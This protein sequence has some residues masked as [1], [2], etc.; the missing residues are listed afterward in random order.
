VV[1]VDYEDG[2]PVAGGSGI[3]TVRSSDDGGETFDDAV[4]MSAERPVGE[5]PML[6]IEA[7]TSAGDNNTNN[8]N[9][10]ADDSNVYISWT[11]D[12]FEDFGGNL[13]FA[14][15]DNSGQSFEVTDLVNYT[16]FYEM[17]IAA[18]ASDDDADKIYVAGSAASERSH[19]DADQIFFQRSTDG[20]KTFDDPI[21]L[22]DTE[23]DEGRRFPSV[24]FGSLEVDDDEIRVAWIVWTGESTFE[25]FFS[26][27]TDGGA[28]FSQPQPE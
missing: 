12:A 24:G 17:E 25:R 21:F 4:L 26:V 27:S 22:D 19:E 11:V 18:A 9:N 10:D 5:I 15:S 16:T 20:G 7:T 8:N 23:L 1:W 3:V 6:Q 28:T 2:E 13:T 14:A